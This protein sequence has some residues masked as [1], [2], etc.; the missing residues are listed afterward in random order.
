MSEILFYGGIAVM[1]LA[2]VC[3]IVSLIVFSVSGKR[4]KEILDREYGKRRH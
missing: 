4:L 1:A 3:G 2:A